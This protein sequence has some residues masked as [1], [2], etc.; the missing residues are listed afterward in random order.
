MNSM[1]TLFY[2]WINFMEYPSQVHMYP[3]HR[4]GKNNDE[5]QNESAV[6]HRRGQLMVCWSYTLGAELWEIVVIHPAGK[7]RQHDE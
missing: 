2:C 1:E 5:G 6:R 3:V 7:N 4:R